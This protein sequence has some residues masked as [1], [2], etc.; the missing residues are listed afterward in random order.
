MVEHLPRMYKSRG[1]TPNTTHEAGVR[2]IVMAHTINPSTRGRGG[3]IYE[4]YLAC[5]K[6]KKKKEKRKR[7]IH[8]S[9]KSINLG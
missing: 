6:G 5:L 4:F 3:Q 7:K 8:A 2:Q 1:P 9:T